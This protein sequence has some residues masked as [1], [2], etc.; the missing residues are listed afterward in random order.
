M[1]FSASA[2][3]PTRRATMVSGPSSSTAT[4][5]KKKEP[6][7]SIDKLSNNAHS[8]RPMVRWIVFIATTP[9]EKQHQPRAVGQ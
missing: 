8:M 3:S 1:A 6:P 5:T 2:A 9:V 4:P 7:H